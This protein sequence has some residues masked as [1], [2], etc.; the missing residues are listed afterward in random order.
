MYS[1]IFLDSGTWNTSNYRRWGVNIT[2]S[3][4]TTE[5]YTGASTT[6]SWTHLMAYTPGTWY[7]IL[8][9]I[10]DD[11][12]LLVAVW[13]RDNPAEHAVLS[14][15][16]A[17]FGS[18]NWAFKAQ[19]YSGVAWL[20]NYDELTLHATQY[21]YDVLDHLTVVTD[22]LGNVTTMAYD[23]LGRKTSMVDPDMGAWSYQYDLAGNLTTQ[24]DARGCVTGF[25]YDGQ[26]RL[27]GK[28]YTG[29]T[30]CAQGPV[31]Y[32]Y[33]QA[34][35]GESLGRRTTM[36][37]TSGSTAWWYDVRGRVTQEVKL[38]G[39]QPFTTST[40][41][42]AMDRVVTTTYP[43]GEGVTTAY[44]AATQPVSL[45]GS[46]TYV[47]E[48]VYSAV[49]QLTR[50]TLGNGLVTTY[51]YDPFASR[52]ATLQTG[53]LLSLAYAYDRVG[54]VVQIDDHQDILFA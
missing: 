10:G 25:T 21:G 43:D 29:A 20:D 9:K 30:G 51:A 32:A 40:S 14:Q 49:G 54:N 22:T 35:Y 50:R 18:K 52:L 42:D 8:I 45:S 4:I 7:R 48:T 12:E 19:V 41:Y 46:S 37:D 5:Q 26:D 6:G 33:D 27:T 17:A 1:I 13:E 36:T 34:G 23:A 24:T 39:T 47:S 11:G 44:N 28:S 15:Q 3:Q 16:N 2:S 53:N 38:I 31:S